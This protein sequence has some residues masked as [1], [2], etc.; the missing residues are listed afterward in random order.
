MAQQAGKRDAG[1]DVVR[2]VAIILVVM[3]HVASDSLSNGVGGLNWWGA[4]FWGALARPAVPL[5]FMCSGALMLG[6]DIPLKRLYGH[7]MLRIVAAMMVWAFG[8]QLVVLIL[9][10]GRP[11]LAGL[12]TAVKNT[13][14]L[15]HGFHF[16]YLHILI[17]VYA[18]L[19]VCRTFVRGASQKDLEYLLIFWFV[20]GILFPLLRYFPPFSMIYT[21]EL[22][23][24]MNMAYAAVGYGVLGRY[25][26]RYGGRIPAVWYGLSLAAGLVLTFAGTA[27]FSLRAGELDE[28]FLEG[29]SPGPMLIALGLFGL[30]ANRE[31]WPVPVARV[32][33]RM[34]LSAFCIY[35]VHPLVM[36]AEMV[37]GLNTAAAPSLIV[38]PLAVLAVLVPSYLSWEVLRRIPIVR[39][40]LI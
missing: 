23:Y 12:W 27:F 34:A 21:V 31:K 32:T 26:K 7:N 6:R 10:Q 4:L 19:P 38:I 33:G 22:W 30:M 16:Y 8:Y 28:R 40:W 35:L 15:E 5:F 36:G 39:T 2:A 3:I 18:F 11:D 17:L 9:E 25:L 14:L 24:M 37:V 20:T 13:L 1:L 29:M